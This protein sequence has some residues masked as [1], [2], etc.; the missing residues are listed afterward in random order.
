MTYVLFPPVAVGRLA[1]RLRVDAG[2]LA[3]YGERAQTRTTDS[4]RPRIHADVVLALELRGRRRARCADARAVVPRAA[5]RSGPGSVVG[6]G[7][8]NTEPGDHGPGDP[9]QHTA[10]HRAAQQA[11]KPTCRHHQQGRPGGA[12]DNVYTRQEH[13]E[14]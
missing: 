2:V 11:L 1:D 3:G 6:G 5:D 4:R 8:T 10:G 14:D 9:V 12:Q 13:P 7:E